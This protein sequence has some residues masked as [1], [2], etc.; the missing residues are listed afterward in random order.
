MFWNRKD[1]DDE[2]NRYMQEREAER[3]GE[4]IKPYSES[5]YYSNNGVDSYHESD[6]HEEKCEYTKGEIGYN[7]A[8]GKITPM[9]DRDERILWAQTGKNRLDCMSS[10]VIDFFALLLLVGTIAAL[11]G[12]FA[13]G[14]SILKLTNSIPFFLVSIYLMFFAG[15]SKV[16]YAITNKRV[17]S[18]GKHTKRSDMLWQISN[19]TYAPVKLNKG[20]ISY[21]VKN[22]GA[23]YN[24]SKISSVLALGSVSGIW[25]VSD[26]REACDILLSLTKQMTQG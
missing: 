12:A 2:Y 13:D 26:G 24:G 7:T 15:K 3:N 9:L 18:V 22:A 11:S 16:Y 19:V 20:N 10:C 4:E 5:E 8:V 23:S 17:I 6:C 21:V 14:F 1:E 25:G